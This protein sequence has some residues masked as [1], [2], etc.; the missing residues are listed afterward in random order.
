MKCIKCKELKT[1]GHVL[2]YTGCYLC[3]EC[4]II[5]MKEAKAEIEALFNL[6]NERCK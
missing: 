1:G 2:K 6:Q 5:L 4:E 3:H